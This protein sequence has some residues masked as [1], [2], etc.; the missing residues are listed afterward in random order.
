M[1]VTLNTEAVILS[2]ENYEAIFNHNAL[3]LIPFK[4]NVSGKRAGGS[5]IW[6]EMYNFFKNNN[7][8]FMKKYHLRSNAESGFSMIKSRFGDLTSIK[9]EVG[10]KNDILCKVL[11]HNLC[12][13]CQELLLLDVD[14]NFAQYSEKVAQD[15]I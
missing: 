6:T 9:N 15:R 3:P 12:V 14:I 5:M 8:L 11:C 1:E 13:L 2:R 4:S 10:A 7:E